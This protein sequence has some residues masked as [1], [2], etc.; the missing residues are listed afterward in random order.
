[1][2]EASNNPV[3]DKSRIGETITPALRQPSFLRVMLF[4]A[5]TVVVFVGMRLSAPILDPILF[6]VVLALLFSPIYAW[7]R[8]HRIPIPLA[9]VIMLV[10]LS[11]L[12][13]GLFFIMGASIARFSG[14]IASYT[15]KLNGQIDNI[16]GTLKNL[17]ISKSSVHDAVKPSDLTGAIGTVLSG[18]ADFLSNLFLILIIV[19]F[20][21]AEGP[22]MMDRL[23]ASAGPEHPQVARLTVF[24]RSVVRQLGL[25]AIVNLF[26]GAGVVI[27]LLVLRVDFPLMWGILTFFLSFIPWIGLPL[28]VAPAVVLALAEHGPTS[29]LLVI[30]G[31]IV[32]NILAEN[33]LSP[34][35]MGRGLS[36]SPT[37]LFIGF[38][39][40]AWLL[41]GPGAFLAAPLT[42]FLILMLDTFPET[43]WLASVMGVSPPDP[44]VPVRGGRW[45][46]KPNE[47]RSASALNRVAMNNPAEQRRS[48]N[49]TLA[50]NPGPKAVP[51]DGSRLLTHLVASTRG[52]A[53]EGRSLPRC[54]PSGPS[55]LARRRRRLHAGDTI[56]VAGRLLEGAA[57][58][59]VSLG[60]RTAPDHELEPATFTRATI[61]R[62]SLRDVARCGKTAY[63]SY[64]AFASIHRSES[65]LL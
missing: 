47:S 37:V 30:A 53:F 61:R 10:G 8:R 36:I 2:N 1:M 5:A 40:W 14:D 39:F 38:M 32:I 58:F 44:D 7:L 28:A 62:T 21:L 33:A 3:D 54:A 45:P 22:A 17:G 23:R 13:L 48:R 26:T 65:A 12:F 46:G 29:A 20:L 60:G 18:V 19:L 9:L 4:L 50:P 43:R 64:F 41:G 15:S 25:R 49:H 34:M 51:R 63:L 57:G 56:P 59:R 42:I 16:Q 24:G 52:R 35:L 27:L 55:G 31:V 6:A 11:V